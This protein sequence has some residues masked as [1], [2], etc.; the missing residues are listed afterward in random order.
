MTTAHQ[1]TPANAAEVKSE[2]YAFTDLAEQYVEEDTDIPLIAFGA[3]GMPMVQFSYKPVRDQQLEISER[4][5]PGSRRWR[6]DWRGWRR[7][8]GAP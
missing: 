8:G 2:S 4:R 1:S 5:S 7:T 6:T 3:L